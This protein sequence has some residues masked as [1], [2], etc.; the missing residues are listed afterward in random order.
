MCDKSPVPSHSVLEPVF[1]ACSHARVS[2]LF[3]HEVFPVI[4]REQTPLLSPG[5]ND[6][7]FFFSFVFSKKTWK[8]RR[9]FCPTLGY[10]YLKHLSFVFFFFFFPVSSVLVHVKPSISEYQ[11]LLQLGS[12]WLKILLLSFKFSCRYILYITSVSPYCFP[13]LPFLHLFC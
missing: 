6:S 9:D 5:P 13:Y 11:V 8:N 3:P 10:G 1:P 4:Q 2:S 12:G 7:F